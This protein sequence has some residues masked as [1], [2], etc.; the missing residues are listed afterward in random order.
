MPI[1]ESPRVIY[2]KNPLV[3]V[4]CQLRFPPILAIP[5]QEPVAFQDKVRGAGYPL[6]N[7]DEAVAEVPAPVSEL[8]AKLRIEVHQEKPTHRFIAEDSSRLIALATDFVAVTERRYQEWKDFREQIQLAEGALEEFYRPAFYSRIGLRYQNRIDRSSLGLHDQPWN[9]L[10]N[11]GL[12]G[13]LADA[14]VSDEVKGIQGNVLMPITEV[15]GGLLQVRHG[16]IKPPDQAPA[17]GIDADFYVE[18]RR[19][20]QDVSGILDRFNRLAGHLFRWAITDRLHKALE[21]TEV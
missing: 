13:V 16:L 17:Y 8:A 11:P 14:A 20:L 15:E 3:E 12:V 7:T 6:Y 5:A 18:E 10:V 4:I 19:A 2:A 9:A 21:P 1:P